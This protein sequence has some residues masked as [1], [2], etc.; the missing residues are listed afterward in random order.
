[1]H[2]SSEGHVFDPGVL[3]GKIWKFILGAIE[4]TEG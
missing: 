3:E 1:M 4:T 2:E